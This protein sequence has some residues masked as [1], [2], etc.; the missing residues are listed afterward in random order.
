M[1]L[2]MIFKGVIMFNVI[3]D[4]K[5]KEIDDAMNLIIELTKDE[6]FKF[7][8]ELYEEENNEVN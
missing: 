4:E 3:S 1:D 2:K 8:D 7:M 6:V 5:Y